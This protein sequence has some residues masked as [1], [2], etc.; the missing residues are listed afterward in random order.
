MVRD[1]DVFAT[2]TLPP[3][4]HPETP[5][6]V[7]QYNPKTGAP[8]DITY[9]GAT[10]V[11]VVDLTGHDVLRDRLEDPEFQRAIEKA[12]TALEVWQATLHLGGD[13]SLTVPAQK[14]IYIDP[15]LDTVKLDPTTVEYGEAVTPIRIEEGRPGIDPLADIANDPSFRKIPV[16]TLADEG[17]HFSNSGE[18]PLALYVTGDGRIKMFDTTMPE[19]GGV[20]VDT[21][22]VEVTP[23][24]PEVGGEGQM[25]MAG[26]KSRSSTIPPPS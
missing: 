3:D 11:P 18:F 12:Y 22:G 15:L 6:Y 21:D 2:S 20:R 16:H 4:A 17:K 19:V 24:P 25:E 13:S 7:P 14:P 10:E 1:I 26:R 5:E 23:P 8:A 9:I